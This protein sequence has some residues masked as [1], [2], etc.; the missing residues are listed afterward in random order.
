MTIPDLISLKTTA[1]FTNYAENDAT[2]KL[3]PS[4]GKCFYQCIAYC[5]SYFNDIRSGGYEVLEVFDHERR[6]LICLVRIDFRQKLVAANSLKR[7][8]NR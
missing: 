1:I 7:F 3:T 4:S 2:T 6:L 5:H 8:E